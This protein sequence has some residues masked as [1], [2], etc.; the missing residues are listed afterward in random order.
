MLS[1]VC[2]RTNK[3]QPFF[4]NVKFLFA[5]GGTLLSYLKF[6]EAFVVE[7]KHNLFA[8]WQ[9]CLKYKQPKIM[10]LSGFNLHIYCSGSCVIKIWNVIAC[11]YWVQKRGKLGALKK[12]TMMEIINYM[13]DNL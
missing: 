2:Y 3:K 11:G 5:E 12:V 9:R 13:N 10:F 1:L 7:W 8:K 4:N 6:R